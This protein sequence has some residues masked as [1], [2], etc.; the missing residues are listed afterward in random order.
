VAHYWLGAISQVW[1]NLDRLIDFKGKFPIYPQILLSYA[2][3]ALIQAGEY[4]K[5]AELLEKMGEIEIE[6]YMLEIAP[7]VIQAKGELALAAGD[8]GQALDILEPFLQQASQKHLLR[9]LPQKLLLKGK[10]LDRAD[11]ADKAYS[12]LQEAQTL[13]AKQQA[14]VLLWQICAQ[15]SEMET[16]RG[17]HVT[18]QALIEEAR[19]AIAYIADHAG[20]EELRDTFLAL[21]QVQRL[22][23]DPGEKHD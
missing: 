15:L 17:N 16:G 11:Q 20:R 21:P 8:H 10:I 14:R 19:T 1:N 18:A 3:L 7:N 12:V 13:A 9:W 5:G 23:S 6:N 4:L 22:Q 2:V